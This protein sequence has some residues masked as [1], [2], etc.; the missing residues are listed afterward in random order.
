MSKLILDEVLDVRGERRAAACHAL[1][2]V[3]AFALCGFFFGGG[4]MAGALSIGVIR[5][6]APVAICDPS[7]ALVKSQI[8]EIQCALERLGEVDGGW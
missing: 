2:C 3:A 5:P 6:R 7:M 8:T 1:K 4:C